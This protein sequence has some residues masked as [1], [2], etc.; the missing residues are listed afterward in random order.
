MLTG[1]TVSVTMRRAMARKASAAAPV[2]ASDTGTPA[3]PAAATDASSGTCPSSGTPIWSARS[4][5]PPS[6]N[7]AYEV[8]CSHVKALMFS[9]TPATRRKLRRAMSAA[10]LATFCAARAGVVT[11]IRSVRGSSRARPICTSP[12]PGGMSMSR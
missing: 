5:P 2:P 6:P 1:G 3:S 11:M 8:P 4:C 12:V 9:I 7:S 10:R